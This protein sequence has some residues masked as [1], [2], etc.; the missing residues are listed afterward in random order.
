MKRNYC[1]CDFMRR[2]IVDFGL[3]LFEVYC[4]SSWEQH[5]P[6]TVGLVT[7][8]W[9]DIKPSI[10]AG[11]NFFLLLLDS[12]LCVGGISLIIFSACSRCYKMCWTHFTAKAAQKQ[13]KPT[14]RE[15]PLEWCWPVWFC[16]QPRLVHRDEKLAQCRSPYLR[17][18]SVFFSLIMTVGTFANVVLRITF[19]YVTEN[20][21]C[22]VCKT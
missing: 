10:K 4:E 3:L 9:K 20:G 15:I 1:E 22:F 21:H 6:V 19:G 18:F 14:A 5:S 17:L 13:Q 2:G 12:N 7:C 16:P 11:L 8:K